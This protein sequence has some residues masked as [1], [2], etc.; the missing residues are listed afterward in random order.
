[1]CSYDKEGLI[2]ITLN[3]TFTDITVNETT[4]KANKGNISFRA[5]DNQPTDTVEISKKESKS[6]AKTIIAA[7]VLLLGGAALGYGHKNYISKGIDM[8][9][10]KTSKIFSEG[11]P[12]KVLQC[13]KELVE[14]VKGFIFAKK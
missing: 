7:T 5:N 3:P 9:K 13:G 10:E 12:A 11:F 2:M 14:K 8:L 4:E 1:M 6:K